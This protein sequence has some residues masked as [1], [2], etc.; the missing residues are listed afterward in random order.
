MIKQITLVTLLI[1]TTYAKEYFLATTGEDR[2]LGTIERPFK[3]IKKALSVLKA[4]DILN[5]R[6]GV[7]PIG[8]KVNISGTRENPITIQAYRDEKVEF[9]GTYGDDKIFDLNQNNAK[10]SFIVTGD[11]L[12]FRNFEVSHG[13]NGLFIK[14]NS[15]HNRFENLKLHDNYYSGMV[16]TDGAE[17]N[18]VINCDSYRNFDSNT[19]GQNADGFVITGRK[20]DAKPFVGVGNIFINCRS[21][22]NSDDGFDAWQAGNPI[23]FINCLAYNNGKDI[24]HKGGFKGDG[25]GFKLGVHNRRGHPRDAHIVIGC[26]AWNNE[27]RGFDSNDNKVAITLYNNVSW[28]NGKSGFKSILTNHIL[29]DNIDIDSGKNYIDRYSFQLNNSWNKRGYNPKKDIIS[30]DDSSIRGER[31]KNGNFISNGFLERR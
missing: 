22:N 26:K 7:Y 3:T 25:N 29:I 13:A 8:V 14:S 10:N 11:W 23:S 4:G 24:W 19:N 18:T 12:I 2:N 30:F 27:G 17:Y 31:D 1:Y 15:A 16:M 20:T 28:K 21:W 6:E 5:I 9:R